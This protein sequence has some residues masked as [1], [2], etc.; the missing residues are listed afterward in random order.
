[1]TRG[2]PSM[3]PRTKTGKVFW[4]TRWLSTSTKPMV[5]DLSASGSAPSTGSMAPGPTSFSRAIAFCLAGL[6]RIV[7]GPDLGDQPVGTQVREKAHSAFTS[8]A[9]PAHTAGSL[10]E[11]LAMSAG[12]I[13]SDAGA[14]SRWPQ[15]G[16]FSHPGQRR[17]MPH[18]PVSPDGNPLCAPGV[19]PL[20]SH[21]HEAGLTPSNDRSELP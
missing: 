13:L 5:A 18:H 6:S 12:A 20:Q 3:R 14:A 4:F 7:R 9:T 8:G 10:H 1:M 15:R 2:L 16:N 19:Q 11:R 21:P 17:S